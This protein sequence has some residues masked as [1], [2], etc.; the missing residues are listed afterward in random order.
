MQT[1]KYSRPRVLLHWCF[2]GIIL[3]TTISGFGLSLVQ[4]PEAAVNA[5][6]FFNVSITAVAVPLFVVRL[7][8]LLIH[9]APATPGHVG[10][11][12]HM[13]IT[14]G[15]FSLYACTALVLI[16]GVLMMD[17][18]ID[19]FGLLLIPQPIQQPAVTAFFNA[20]HSDSCLLLALLVAGHIAAVLSHSL[21]GHSVLKRMSI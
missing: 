21:R 6:H 16:T 15:H 14:A 7:L 20:V 12:N 9:P 5:I 17:R 11:L 2:A 1:F 10:R 19:I 18:P 13:L 3:W 4:L 8:Y